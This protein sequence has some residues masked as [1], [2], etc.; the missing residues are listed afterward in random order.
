M[1]VNYIAACTPQNGIEMQAFIP[2]VPGYHVNDM[3]RC[4]Q[5]LSDPSYLLI[6]DG[7]EDWFGSGMYF[8]DTKGN[9][10][11]WLGE[12]QRK[13][14][15]KTYCCVS[16]SILLDSLFD[17]TDTDVLSMLTRLWDT[18]CKKQNTI[19]DAEIKDRKLGRKID[20]LFNFFPSL[21]SYTAIKGMGYYDRYRPH[22]TFFDYT[23]KKAKPTLQAKVIY[24]VLSPQKA[25]NRKEVNL[26]E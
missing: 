7:D 25:L 17:L 20:I 9:A 14:S 13:D 26:D 11:Y 12:K 1:G 8:W 24:S 16:A 18:Y 21:Q 15:A 19:G 6:S 23:T 4:T 22:P 10:S 5:F 2:N 3:E